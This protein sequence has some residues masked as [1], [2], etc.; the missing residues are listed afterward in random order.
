MA[1]LGAVL[2][3]EEADVRKLEGLSL[4]AMFSQFL[5]NK[6]DHLNKERQEVLT[7]KLKYDQSA[8]EVASLE[9]DIA[10]MEGRLAAIGDPEAEYAR[11]LERKEA[12]IEGAGP[13]RPGP[14]DGEDR[15]GQLRHQG[16]RRGRRSGR[17]GYRRA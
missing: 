14:V 13:R 8:H 9:R 16:D 11:A 5:G 6:E 10:D 2:K 4:T 15:R 17:R 1:E 12:R 7:A 3:K